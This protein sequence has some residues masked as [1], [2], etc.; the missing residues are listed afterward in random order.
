MD[1]PFY[2]WLN[3]A[4]DD[5][6]LLDR[7]LDD[8][9]LTHLSAFHSQ[10][11]IEKSLKALL[12]YRNRNI[13]KIHSLNRLFKLCENDILIVD[14]D[15]I[16]TLDSLY[17]ESRYPGEFGY[18]PYGKPSLEAGKIFYDFAKVIY[19]KVDSIIKSGN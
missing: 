19:D 18:L 8:E 10:Q 13:L 15:V 4:H 3:A 6:L 2:E 5:L 12:E 9:K 11:A 14:S 16:N 1:R 7:I 17:V